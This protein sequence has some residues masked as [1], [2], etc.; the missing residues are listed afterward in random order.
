MALFR[1]SP[2]ARGLILIIAA[3]L[4]LG[5]ERSVS[6][7]PSSKANA[8]Q[9]DAALTNTILKYFSYAK[10]SSCS[11]GLSNNTWACASAVCS[12]NSVGTKVLG[13]LSNPLR[14]QGYSGYVAIEPDGAT[15]VFAIE[16][17]RSA[18]DFLFDASLT[19]TFGV[20]DYFPDAPTT[21]SA[22][23]GFWALFKA[24][25]P[26]IQ[27]YI[28]NVLPQYPNVKTVVFAGYSLGGILQNLNAGYFYPKLSSR[29]TVKSYIVAPARTINDV[30]AEYLSASP[31]YAE[32]TFYRVIGRKDI[33]PRIITPWAPTFYTHLG[34]E[35]FV[36]GEAGVTSPIYKCP[37]PGVG[38]ENQYCMNTVTPFELSVSP[39]HTNYFGITGCSS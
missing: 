6:A 32:G 3:F 38:K 27:S 29:Y 8:V 10:A 15:V 5:F 18:V 22:H 36:D 30:F 17:T 11:V 2:P 31:A 33:V 13:E 35:Y 16:G 20:Q 19:P 1:V 21:S 24:G 23:S 9:I 26:S 28:D 7:A 4:A 34:T 37:S 25:V 12:G 39:G 14:E